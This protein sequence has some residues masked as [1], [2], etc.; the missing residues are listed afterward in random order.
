MKIGTDVSLKECQ[1][2]GYTVMDYKVREL[3]PNGRKAA[4]DKDGYTNLYQSIP[5]HMRGDMAT[6]CN[7]FGNGRLF[8]VSLCFNDVLVT[9][10]SHKESI[11]SMC[12]MEC[13]TPEQQAN[14][15]EY[16]FLNLADSVHACCGLG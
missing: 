3:F 4:M 13:C 7:P 11:D 8:D 16:I 6:D 14:P 12:G 10:L 1:A 15:D 9:Y 5:E 2:E